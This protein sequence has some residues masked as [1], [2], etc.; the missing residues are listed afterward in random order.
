[1]SLLLVSCCGSC[2]AAMGSPGSAAVPAGVQSRAVSWGNAAGG[3]LPHALPQQSLASY[4]V[5]S[6]RSSASFHAIPTQVV[7]KLHAG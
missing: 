5:G 6:R 7:Y 3:S 1:M 4:V 2:A